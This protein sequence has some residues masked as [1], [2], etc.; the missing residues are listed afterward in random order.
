MVYSLNE[1][2]EKK[3]IFYWCNATG[4]LNGPG[5]SDTKSPELEE[6]PAKVREV[7]ERFWT[8]GRGA[9]EYVVTLNGKTGLMLGWLFDYGYLEDLQVTV[10]ANDPIQK[11]EYHAAV[12]AAANALSYDYRNPV[13]Y[14]KDT[15]PEGDEILLF[16]EY[17][18]LVKAGIHLCILAS[19]DRISERLFNHVKEILTAPTKNVKPAPESA[20]AALPAWLYKK[21]HDR[22]YTELVECQTRLRELGDVFYSRPVDSTD[23]RNARQS[24]SVRKEQEE[25]LLT[26]IA[27]L[28]KYDPDSEEG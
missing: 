26:I 15:D 20:K 27:G 22:L 19:L 24:Y 13:I 6:L 8:E 10:G 14:G 18:D 3:Q 12:Y 21:L 23:Y 1:F 4:D 17:D 16:F 5:F 2:Y 9:N 11:D 28:K 25:E 7:Y